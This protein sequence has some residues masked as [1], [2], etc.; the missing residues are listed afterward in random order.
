VK[1]LA[2]RDASGAIAAIYDEIRRLWAVPYV[3]SMQRHLATR[4]GWLEWVWAALRPV[5]V[6]GLA[7]TTAWSTCERV[8][9]IH[10]APISRGAL[11]VWG[12]EH[13][14]EASIRAAC[15]NFLRASPTNL[16]LSGLLRMLLAGK[17]PGGRGAL[18]RP[19]TPPPPVPPLPPLV[20]VSQLPASEQRVL[21]SLSTPIEGEDFVPGLYRMLARWPSFLAHVATVLGPHLHGTATHGA[22]AQMLRAIDDQIQGIFESL[23]ALPSSPPMP[24]SSGFDDVRAVLDGYRKTSPEMIVFSRAI[25]DALPG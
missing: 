15:D 7:Q 17:R 14:G 18:H 16:V 20:E 5:F 8:E 23:P 12:V 6:S 3:S 13:D 22:C 1:E 10:L 21:L 24:P 2:E 19:W 4:P 11:R 9:G 25:R